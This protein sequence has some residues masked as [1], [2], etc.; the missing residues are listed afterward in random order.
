MIKKHEKKEEKKMKKYEL[1]EETKIVDGVILYRIKAVKD[2][3]AKSLILD[4]YQNLI[5]LIFYL[6]HSKN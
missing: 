6:F 2:F 1:T 3:K 5:L 4:H